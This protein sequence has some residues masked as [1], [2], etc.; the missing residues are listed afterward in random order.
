MM[1]GAFGGSVS[2]Q[3][4]IGKMNIVVITPSESGYFN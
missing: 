1:S 3:G 4:H 2:L